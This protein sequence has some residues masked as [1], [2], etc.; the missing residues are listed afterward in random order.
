MKPPALTRTAE[1]VLVAAAYALPLAVVPELIHDAAGLPKT[2][3]LIVTTALLVGTGLARHLVFRDA[4]APVTPL[5]APLLVFAG[6]AAV[7]ALHTGAPA[8]T[9]VALSYLGALLTV[10]IIAS[11]LPR[12]SVVLNAMLVAGA[13]AGLYG[14]GQYLGFEP[15]PWASH[16]RPR[17]FSTLGNP[18]FLGGYMAALF[19]LTMAR[20]LYTEEEE[21]K[22]LL[23]LLLVV[24]ALAAYLTWTRSAWLALVVSTA[25]QFGW[26]LATPHGR[27]LVTA[28]R[29]WLLTVGVVGLIV[30]IGVSTSSAIGAAPV[31]I[32]DRL[33]DAV[34]TGGYS[35]RFRLANDE[36][37]C[38]IAAESPV[39]GCGMGGYFARYPW[40]RQRTWA[41][42]AAPAH[43]FA[44]QEMFAHNDHLQVL[45][46]T[47]VPGFGL[48]IWLLCCTARWTWHRFRNGDWLGLGAI[49][50]LVAVG[51]DGLLNFPLRIAPTA[52]VLAATL[53]LLAADDPAA[54]EAIPAAG[55]RAPW[56]RRSA[57]TALIAGCGLAVAHP[58]WR[59][60]VADRQTG[61][62]DRQVASNNYEMA[63]VYYGAGVDVDPLDRFLN[64][65]Y[66]VAAANAGRYEWLGGALDDA[67]RHTRRALALGYHDENVYKHLSDLYAR[68]TAMPQA[69]RALEIAWQLDPER[70]DIANNLSYYLA[71]C[72]TRLEEAVTLARGAVA[73]TPE[74]P[75][76]LDTLGYALASAGHHAEAATVL[77]HA[78]RN[79]PPIAGNYGRTMARREIE[80]HL[81]LA[82]SAP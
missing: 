34:N 72:G 52:W 40:L 33:A 77:R 39:A 25:V 14:I 7:S 51:T 59:L 11:A 57:A 43:F 62:G 2:V 73:H 1:A 13:L 63:A 20:W 64:F 30:A 6:W 18:V 70:Q 48:W 24:L 8:E 75:V 37:C 69:I 56:W 49:G 28:N 68:K 65:R 60:I 76:Y 36:V 17:I 67:M 5:T 81:R 50:C 58:C 27:T 44:S 53:G 32:A 46:E 74:D 79:L 4:I 55:P 29:T 35:A 21:A 61:E 78:L 71:V 82:H 47:G 9:A 41:A 38:R 80:D 10:V 66:G 54:D 42:R 22:D 19:P 45:A 26:L 15:L 3:A 16:F 31:P 23:T 12:R